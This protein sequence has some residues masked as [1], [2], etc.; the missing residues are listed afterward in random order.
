VLIVEDDDHFYTIL[1]TALRCKWIDLNAVERA[2]NLSEVNAAIERWLHRFKMIIFDGNLTDHS[3][4]N[5]T[6]V[7]K[8]WEIKHNLWFK[9]TMIASSWSRDLQNKQINAWCDFA[10]D[11][12]KIPEIIRDMT[13]NISERTWDLL[14][15]NA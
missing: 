4:F 6:T 11:K 12:S 14:E 10:I 8:I 3:E 5:E 9:W 2:R 1:K 13:Q 15:M 7:E